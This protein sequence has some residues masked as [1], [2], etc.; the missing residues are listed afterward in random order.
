[1]MCLF[2]YVCAV[3]VCFGTCVWY[4][5]ACWPQVHFLT[6]SSG[7]CLVFTCLQVL[8]LSLLKVHALFFQTSSLIQHL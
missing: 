2:W 1:M 6:Y 4:V 5:F 3:C 7:L 8:L